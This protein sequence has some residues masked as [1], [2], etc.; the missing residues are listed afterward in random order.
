MPNK[1]ILF[2]KVHENLRKKYTTDFIH[3]KNNTIDSNINIIDNKIS[4]LNNH[5][6]GYSTTKN[7]KN[8]IEFIQQSPKYISNKFNHSVNFDATESPI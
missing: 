6:R 7:I 3:L 5:E 4:M 8:N 2:A 1:N